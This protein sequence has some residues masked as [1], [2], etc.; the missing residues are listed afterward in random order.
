MTAIETMKMEL[1]K[2]QEAQAECITSWGNVKS[3]C[4]YKYQILCRKARSFKDSIE[5]MEKQIYGS[6]Q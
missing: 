4:R 3:E 1:N 6:P 2:I 5:F